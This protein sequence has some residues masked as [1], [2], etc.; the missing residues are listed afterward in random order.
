MKK[1]I[2]SQ[3]DVD[4]FKDAYV[5]DFP[6]GISI[7]ETYK[8]PIRRYRSYSNDYGNYYNPFSTTAFFYGTPDNL[9]R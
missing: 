8:M 2:V 9:F 4:A 5:S 7:R 1:V 3:V 6:A